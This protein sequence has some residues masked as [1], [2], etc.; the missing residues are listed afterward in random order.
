VRRKLTIIKERMGENNKEKG[1]KKG[2]EKQKTKKNCHNK[3]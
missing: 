1:K 3:A 2:D